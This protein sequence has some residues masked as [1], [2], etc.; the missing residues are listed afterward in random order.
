MTSKS[1][2]TE[3]W[4][5]SL[6]ITTEIRYVANQLAQ[7]Q[8][9]RKKSEQ[10]WLNTIAVSVV[11]NYLNM[12]SIQ[13]DLLSSDSW[14]PVIQLC[15]DSA[16]LIVSG[17]GKLEC[18]PVKSGMSSCH[19]PLEVLNLRIGYTV[20]EID[21]SLKEAKI[22]G[23]SAAASEQ[24]TLDNL[25]PLEALINRIHELQSSAIDSKV[26]DLAQWL[27]DVFDAGWQSIES[28]FSP[29][30]LTPALSFRHRDESNLDRFDSFA[31]TEITKAKTIDLGM[32]LYDLQL[33]VLL[34]V[35]PEENNS[36]SITLQIHP[37]PNEPYLPETLTL[38][39]LEDSKKVLMEAQARNQD[40]FIQLQFSGKPKEKFTVEIAFEEAIF[41]E[42]FII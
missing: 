15:S 34:K 29:E 13:T 16:D 41:S 26:T 17:V 32:Q 8:L 35:I 4:A 30:Q 40:N 22:L 28:L 14:N 31:G 37:Q 25:Q 5:I 20:V 24:L 21:D 9:N 38:R 27:N 23:F 18:R 3:N 19:I 6:P 12:L 10:V 1:S 36:V 7:K 42:S 2:E 33:I 11:N 39:I